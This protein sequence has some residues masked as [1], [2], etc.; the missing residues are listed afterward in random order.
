MGGIMTTTNKSDTVEQEGPISIRLLADH[1]R[2]AASLLR[3]SGQRG[4]PMSWAPF[5][6]VAVHAIELYLTAFLLH[7]GM[8]ADEVRQQ[9]GH[10][11]GKRA[12]AARAAGLILRQRT[13]EHLVSLSSSKEY[14]VSRYE[15]SGLYTASELNRLT[16][17]LDEVTHKTALASAAFPS[18]VV[19]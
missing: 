5:R 2:R 19:G 1:Y 13:Y 4:S 14:R 9:M 3:E 12:D 10:H 7:R 11:L 8:S 6:L 17:T 16:A 15:P 18:A